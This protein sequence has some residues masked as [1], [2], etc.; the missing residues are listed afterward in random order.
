MHCG[1]LEACPKSTS[2]GLASKL[3]GGIVWQGFFFFLPQSFLRIQ[4]FKT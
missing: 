4:P 3:G 1:R 2:T